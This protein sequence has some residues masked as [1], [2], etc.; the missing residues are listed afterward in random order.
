MSDGGIGKD[1]GVSYWATINIRGDLSKEQ[2]QAVVKEL[3]KIMAKSVTAA[4]TIGS[5]G[6]P[7]EGVVV[8][9]A[10]VTEGEPVPLGSP[11]ST[12]PKS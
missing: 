2:L 8:Q 11:G 12:A 7:I 5:D 9:A 3:K 6:Q 10:R 1:P 4:G